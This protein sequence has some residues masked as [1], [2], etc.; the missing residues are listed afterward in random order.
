V[1]N[2]GNSSNTNTANGGQG[3]QGGQG[4]KGGTGV[5][6]GVGIGGGA[7]NNGNGNGNGNGS[8]NSTTANGGTSNAN[9]NGSNNTTNST[10]AATG[11]GSN[12]TTS[13]GQKQGQ[14]QQQSSTSS[15]NNTGGNSSNSY[16]STNDETYNAAKIPANTA[17]APTTLPTVPCLKTYSGGGQGSSFGFSFGGGKVDKNCALLETAR[18]FDEMNERL[19]G[20]KVKISS[21]YAK[22]AGVTLEDCMA[23]EM[24]HVV[25]PP[26]APVV[27][28]APVVPPQVVV[29]QVPVP[30][31]APAPVVVPS[32]IANHQGF[33][34]RFDNVAK[35]RFDGTI[36][37][38]RNSPDSRLRLRFNPASSAIANSIETYLAAN[39]IDRERVELRDDGYEKGVEVL[40]IQ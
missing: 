2:S 15:A 35:A 20:C 27:E 8:N 30:A 18:S 5:G 32:P 28:K 10:S 31:P 26:P 21:D 39:G 3:G 11:N 22:K 17:Y 24:V 12:N 37:L 19:A 38:M 4:G 29:V 1:N 34:T 14:G 9:G 23:V 36:L 16:S 7:T 40:Y 25:T 13:Q 33:Y 6:V